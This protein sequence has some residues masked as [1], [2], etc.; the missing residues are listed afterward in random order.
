M[1]TNRKGGRPPSLLVDDMILC[2]KH[3]YLFNNDVH[4]MLYCIPL[5]VY[6]NQ[7]VKNPQAK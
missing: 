1:F 3:V 6:V 5:Q 2:F 4:S 7:K